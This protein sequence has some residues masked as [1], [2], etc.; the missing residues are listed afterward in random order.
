MPNPFHLKINTPDGTSYEDDV[1]QVELKT[2]NG[3]IGFLAEH[4]PSVGSILPSI[5]YIKDQ[6]GNRVSAVINTGI[7]KM[8]GKQINVITDFFN[9]TDRIDESVFEL[10]RKKIEQ[11][12]NQKD[13]KDVKIYEQ[14]QRKLEEEIKELSE[15][16]KK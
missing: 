14:I 2:P 11:A 3:M 16:S 5:C 4:Q 7:Y 1:L 15:I 9:F 12:I 6:K 13:I 8:D 10:R